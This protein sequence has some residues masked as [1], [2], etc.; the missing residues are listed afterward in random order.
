[1]KRLWLARRRRLLFPEF[2]VTQPLQWLHKGRETRKAKLGTRQPRRART[3]RLLPCLRSNRH[4][5]RPRVVLVLW[6]QRLRSR[7]E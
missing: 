1:M 4:A 7:R 6:K 3:I 5:L 2:L